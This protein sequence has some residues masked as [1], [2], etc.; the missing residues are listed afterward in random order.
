MISWEIECRSPWKPKGCFT[1]VT[2]AHGRKKEKRKTRIV[3]GMKIMTNRNPYH[4]S[5]AM[6][7]R[8]IVESN[9]L[10]PRHNENTKQSNI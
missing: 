2:K 7:L 10:R 1:H 3:G 5:K 4:F 6:V 8:D 9:G